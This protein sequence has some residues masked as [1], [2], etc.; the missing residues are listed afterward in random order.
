M[1]LLDNI[2]HQAKIYNSPTATPKEKSAAKKKWSFLV[3]TFQELMGKDHKF[4]LKSP[5]T[6]EIKS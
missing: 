6:P 5:N 3:E 2:Q 4:T 1:R